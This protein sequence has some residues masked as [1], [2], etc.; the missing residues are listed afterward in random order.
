MET[1]SFIE[2]SQ[3]LSVV[4]S[5]LLNNNVPEGIFTLSTYKSGTQSSSEFLLIPTPGNQSYFTASVLTQ[6]QDQNI[7]VKFN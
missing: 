6:I 5:I 3:K 1:Q 7:I 4:K 2:M